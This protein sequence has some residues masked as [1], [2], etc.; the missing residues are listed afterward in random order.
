MNTGYKVLGIGLKGFLPQHA[1]GLTRVLRIKLSNVLEDVI[2]HYKLQEKVENKSFVYVKYVCGMYGLPHA[3]IIAQKLLEERLE[4]MATTR[5][6][7]H[8]VSGNTIRDQ[9]ASHS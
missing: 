2:E 5:V 9:S 4:S 7:R 1:D 3:G 6:I 8:Q